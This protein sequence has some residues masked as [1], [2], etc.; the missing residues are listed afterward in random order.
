M[1]HL[2]YNDLGRR[3]GYMVHYYGHQRAL[4]NLTFINISS[5]V[6]SST[7]LKLLTFLMIK[8]FLSPP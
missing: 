3:Q 8:P 5:T 7:Q 1:K 2:P 6:N 4:L